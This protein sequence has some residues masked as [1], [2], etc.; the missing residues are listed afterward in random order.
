M[1]LEGGGF[2][3]FNTPSR[4]RQ[5]ASGSTIN[6]NKEPTTPLPLPKTDKGKRNKQYRTTIE[7]LHEDNNEEKQQQQQHRNHA[8]YKAEQNLLLKEPIQYPN[9]ET[10]QR[11]QST[12]YPSRFQHPGIQQGYGLRM[13]DKLLAD[14]PGKSMK[15]I[16]N[17]TLMFEGNNFTAFLK[18]YEREE[19]VLN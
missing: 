14:V 7:D 13:G 16:K 9:E 1:D 15:I 2:S 19:R 18:R 6:V 3:A 8:Q 4:T 10:P 11:F 17:P 5:L 12:L